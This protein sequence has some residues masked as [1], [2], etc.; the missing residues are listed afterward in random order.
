MVKHIV[1]W[2]IKDAVDGNT[3][4]ESTLL[5]KAALEGLRGKI[6]EIQS[7]EVGLNFNPAE[8]ACDLSLHTEFK[9]REDLDRYQKHPEHVKVAELVKKLAAERRVS[10]Y[11]TA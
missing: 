10:D 7:L 3:K 5:L 1:L 6:P 8:T 4:Q 11:E 9:S 2:K